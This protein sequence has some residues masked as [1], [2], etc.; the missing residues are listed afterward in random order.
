MRP[1]T[2]TGP[3]I[4]VIRRA[5]DVEEKWVTAPQGCRLSRQQ[6]EQAVRF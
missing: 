5:D 4:A 3:V 6:I 2:F 1:E